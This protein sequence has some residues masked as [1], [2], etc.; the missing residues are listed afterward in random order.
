MKTF[1]VATLLLLAAACYAGQTAITD[2]GEKVILNS[3]GT[4]VYSHKA[5]TPDTKIG[6]NKEKFNKPND[7]TF[8]LKSTKTNSAFWIN[9]DKWSFEK[10]QGE[11]EYQF[12][13][14]DK[15]LFGMAITEPVEIPLEVLTDLALENARREAP[16][17]KIVM[18]EYRIVNGNKVIYMEMN[19]TVKGMN[20]TYHGHYYSNSSGTTQL[21]AYTFTKVVPSYKSEIND[22][23][24]SLATQ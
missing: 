5:P 1:L 24:N 2:T 12:R 21:I 16:D 3:D 22:F 15:P 10:K 23:L 17:A 7:S 8:L 18:K 20:F 9:T 11:L 13:L 19:G 4:W 6:T 14:K